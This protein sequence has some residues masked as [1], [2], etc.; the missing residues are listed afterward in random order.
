MSQNDIRKEQP[1]ECNLLVSLDGGVTYQPAPNGVRLVYVDV[2][3]PGEERDEEGELHINATSEGL[4]S[5]IW[6]TREEPHDHNLA[7]DSEMVDAIVSRLTEL[8]FMRGL[9]LE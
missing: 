4:V 8:N 2:P 5:D 1:S 6:V 3:V 7:T 9:A